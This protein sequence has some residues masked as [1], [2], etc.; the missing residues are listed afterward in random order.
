MVRLGA[1][2]GLLWIP[3]GTSNTR[4]ESGSESGPEFKSGSGSG[5]GPGPSAPFLV[6][7]A[8]LGPISRLGSPWTP[9]GELGSDAWC[10]LEIRSDANAAFLVLSS[11]ISSDRWATADGGM[12]TVTTRPRG[13]AG[14]LPHRVE[15]NPL[16]Q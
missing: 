12:A 1:G 7:V 16:R 11:S 13:N 9:F 5:P 8:T 3:G 10:P 14:L 15:R 4:S 6:A 2:S